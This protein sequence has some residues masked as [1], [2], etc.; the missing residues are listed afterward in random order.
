MGDA[1]WTVH[2][3]HAHLHAGVLMLRDGVTRPH[4]ES[5]RDG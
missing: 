5:D 2:R 3:G 4:R 1:E